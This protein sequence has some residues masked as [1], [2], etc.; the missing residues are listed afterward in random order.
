MEAQYLMEQYL[1]Y[2]I[3]GKGKYDCSIGYNIDDLAMKITR[4]IIPED[5]FLNVKILVNMFPIKALSP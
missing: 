4:G 1:M 5:A 3:K 2:N